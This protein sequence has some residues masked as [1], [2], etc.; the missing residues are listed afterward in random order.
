MV[1]V[2]QESEWTGERQSGGKNHSCHKWMNKCQ[3]RDILYANVDWG[4]FLLFMSLFSHVCLLCVRVKRC[5]KV[6]LV[7]TWSVIIAGHKAIKV[8]TKIWP[9]MKDFNVSTWITR[10]S[11]FWH[12]SFLEHSL[13]KEGPQKLFYKRI[14]MDTVHTY[15]HTVAVFKYTLLSY[16]VT[17]LVKPLTSFHYR[18]QLL[19]R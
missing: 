18:F 14:G 12:C 6:A 4:L 8:T 9:P 15:M 10:E 2:D 7:V 13:T 16:L 5:T 3:V 19:K 17:S 11:C 1:E